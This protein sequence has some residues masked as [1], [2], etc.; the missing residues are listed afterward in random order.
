[1]GG[2]GGRLEWLSMLKLPKPKQHKPPED[3]GDFGAWGAC[4]QGAWLRDHPAEMSAE[5]PVAS[6]AIRL[7]DPGSGF[8]A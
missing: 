8:R 3:P 5:S 4:P 6:S 7:S 2:R 1:M